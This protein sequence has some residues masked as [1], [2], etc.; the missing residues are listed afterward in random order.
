[1]EVKL[2]MGRATVSAGKPVHPPYR[3]LDRPSGV[4]YANNTV[5]SDSPDFLQFQCKM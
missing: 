5:A 4:A 2:A 1:M 3:V